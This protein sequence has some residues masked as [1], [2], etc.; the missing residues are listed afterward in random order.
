MIKFLLCFIVLV[1]MD[2]YKFSFIAEISKKAFIVTNF[3]NTITCYFK[4]FDKVISS[5]EGI[6][7]MYD[8]GLIEQ[9]EIIN[10]IK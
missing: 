7:F 1:Y 5:K 6:Q 3:I 4:T 8:I 9:G 10:N 2:D